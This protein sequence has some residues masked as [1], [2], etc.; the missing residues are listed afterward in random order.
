[1]NFDDVGD[2]EQMEDAMG[3]YDMM[4]DNGEGSGSAEDEMEVD[5][6]DEIDDDADSDSDDE[7]MSSDDD[8]GVTEDIDEDG[9]DAESEDDEDSSGDS[10]DDAIDEDFDDEAQEAEAVSWDEENDDFLEGPVQDERAEGGGAISQGEFEMDEGWTRIES[11]GFGGMFARRPGRAPGGTNLSARASRG[12]IDDAEAMIGTL[13]RN[14][15]IDS[16]ALSEIEG[17]LGIRIVNHGRDPQEPNG[18][19]EDNARASS[20]RP[21]RPSTESALAAMPKRTLPETLPQSAAE[22][23]RMK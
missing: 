11:N 21:L 15:D 19:G 10:Q 5:E 18:P 12:F 9:S 6:E 14:G 23:C 8:S 13:L 17:T 2:D 16:N 1:M 3:D 7:D 4:A 20:A 22:E